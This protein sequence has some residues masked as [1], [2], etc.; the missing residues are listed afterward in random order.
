MC[1]GERRNGEAR[2]DLGW[3]FFAALEVVAWSVGRMGFE[4]C[5]DWKAIVNLTL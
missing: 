2:I 4:E 5:E 1:L 3:T